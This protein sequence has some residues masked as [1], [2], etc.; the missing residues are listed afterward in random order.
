M[1]ASGQ[2][3]KSERAESKEGRMWENEQAMDVMYQLRVCQDRES[4]QQIEG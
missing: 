2:K 3:R 1:I 4:M